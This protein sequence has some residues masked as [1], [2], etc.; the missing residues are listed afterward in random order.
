MRKK[1]EFSRK[2][3]ATGVREAVDVFSKDDVAGIKLPN[4]T[5]F[6]PLIEKF[7]RIKIIVIFVFF[8]FNRYLQR[9]R[10]TLTKRVMIRR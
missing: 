8:R 5:H 2:F 4:L 9:A 6:T 7:E 10:V 1:F 3:R